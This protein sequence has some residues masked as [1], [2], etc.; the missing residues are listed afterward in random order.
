MFVWLFVFPFFDDPYQPLSGLGN[1]N[2]DS[3][4]NRCQEK[5]GNASN[6]PGELTMKERVEEAG[7][8]RESLQTTVQDWPV[9][10]QGRGKN[11]AITASQR[12]FF[13]SI[14]DFPASATC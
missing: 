1:L 5:N 2:L 6:L 9:T 11:L 13:Q 7:L 10:G 8:G 3:P 12:A 4:T 14:E